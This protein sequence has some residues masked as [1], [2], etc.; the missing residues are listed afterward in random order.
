MAV[1]I[2]L[3]VVMAFLIHSLCILCMAIDIINVTFLGMAIFAI[4]SS[5]SGIGNSIRS[6]F[7]DLFRH[8][9]RLAALCVAGFGLL[10]AAAL[11]GPRLIPAESPGHQGHAHSSSGQCSVD[12]N[13]PAADVQRGV[14]P[15]G[16]PWIGAANPT[17]EVQEFTDYECPFCRKAHMTVRQLLSSNPGMRVYHRHFPLDN[18]CNPGIAQPFHAR[19]C[20]LSRAAVCAQDQGRFWEMNDLLFQQSQEIKED[21]IPVAELAARLELDADRFSC[22]MADDSRFAT[23]RADLAEGNRLGLKGTPAFIIN[24]NVYYGKIPPEVLEK[25]DSL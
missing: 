15:D 13:G 25:S 24:G 12:E 8:P 4:K 22:C 19:A 3:V 1:S 5:G 20:E 21:D 11:I 7:A 17:V 2:W 23:M 18:S 6:D 16:H 14:S 9:L 10:A